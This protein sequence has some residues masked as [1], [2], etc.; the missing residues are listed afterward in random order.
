MR[1]TSTIRRRTSRTVTIAMAVGLILAGCGVIG[2]GVDETAD[3]GDNGIV[4][5]QEQLDAAQAERDESEPEPEALSSDEADVDAEGEASNGEP[6]E[7]DPEN[8]EIAIAEAEEDELDGFFNAISVF[9]ACIDDEG[10]EFIG[11]PGQDGATTEDFESDYLAVLGAC[12]TESEILSAF[13]AFGEAQANLSPAE[14][15]QNNFGLPTFKE[16]MEDLGWTVE[17]LVP[18]ERGALGFG[19]TGIG[20][21]PPEGAEGL[22]FDDANTCRTTAEQYVA[23]NYVADEAG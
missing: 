15:A 4:I 5:S 11:A 23:D 14:I 1:F 7:D 12:A 10:Y 9:N 20:L 6:E 13:Q 18:D 21:Q 17:D 22:N 8:D 16:C 3:D 19:A 2:I